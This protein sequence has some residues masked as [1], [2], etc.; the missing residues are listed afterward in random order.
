VFSGCS[1][2]EAASETEA[3]DWRSNVDDG[4][5]GGNAEAIAQK[6]QDGSAPG[7]RGGADIIFGI[8]VYRVHKSK[9]RTRRS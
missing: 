4:G 7:S 2:S 6:G 9:A 1:G 5:T 8:L 3:E